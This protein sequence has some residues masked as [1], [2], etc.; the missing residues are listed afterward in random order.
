[1]ACA[2]DQDKIKLE[3]RPRPTLHTCLGDLAAQC[4][5]GPAPEH[6]D[7]CLANREQNHIDIHIYD[8]S[9]W[10]LVGMVLFDETGWQLPGGIH[11]SN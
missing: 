9:E 2:T 1:M 4:Q 11:F 6:A 3:L 5:D 8:V 10:K 7:E